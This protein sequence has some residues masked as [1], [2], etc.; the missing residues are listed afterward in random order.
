MQKVHIGP[1]QTHMREI[2][3]EKD[4]VN[5]RGV[6]TTR[7]RYRK[8]ENDGKSNKEQIAARGRWIIP[9]N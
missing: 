8:R 3:N 4:G 6:A 5:I 1:R 2:G 9:H 7:G